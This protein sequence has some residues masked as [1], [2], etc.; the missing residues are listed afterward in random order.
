MKVVS[1]LRI[2]LLFGNHFEQI[3]AC[4][5]VT[6]VCSCQNVL[7]KVTFGLVQTDDFLF[8]GVLADQVINGHSTVL[9]DAVACCSI[10]GFH[11]GSRWNT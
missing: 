10:A 1:K 9:S 8:D 11:H 2:I 7:S 4:E 3:F 5:L 6:E